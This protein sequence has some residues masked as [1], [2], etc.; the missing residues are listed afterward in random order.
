MM[1][2]NLPPGCNSADGGIDHAMEAALDDLCMA[3]ETVEQ[4]QALQ[5]LLPA[6]KIMLYTTYSIGHE[7]GKME[8]AQAYDSAMKEQPND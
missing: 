2:S 8:A 6:V 1:S 4:A 3:I 5:A 7:E